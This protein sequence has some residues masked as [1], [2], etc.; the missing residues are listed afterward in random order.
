MIETKIILLAISLLLIVGSAT[1]WRRAR[2][3]DGS[4]GWPTTTGI[5]QRSEIVENRVGS[6][7]MRVYVPHIEY[8]YDVNGRSFHGSTL[9][10]GADRWYT[11]DPAPATARIERFSVGA[12]VTVYYDPRRPEDSCLERAK[13]SIG[14]AYTIP[15]LLLIGGLG[16]GWSVVL[17]S[18]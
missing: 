6:Q 1:H 11:G 17:V 5:V 10:E 18:L 14:I 7:G 8:R 13:G 2:R 15:L 16:L 4:L 12:S 9:T 3:A